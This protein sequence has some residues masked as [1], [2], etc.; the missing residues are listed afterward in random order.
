MWPSLCRYR[1]G[2]RHESAD[3]AGLLYEL[4]P[5]TPGLA[6]IALEIFRIVGDEQDLGLS[7]L[8]KGRWRQWF[9]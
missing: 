1:R 7:R 3:K 6:T 4:T 5:N 2:C 9:G 8:E